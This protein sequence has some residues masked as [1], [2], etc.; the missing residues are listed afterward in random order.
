MTLL[1]NGF[2][3]NL[4]GKL[5]GGRA[6]DGANP[7]V[8]EYLGHRTAALRNL[9][10]GEG[11]RNPQASAPAGKRAPYAWIMAQSGGG[12]SSY[13]RTDIAVNAQ[14]I[15]EM[16]FPRGG[17]TT[18]TIDGVGVLGLV[19]GVSG[20]TTISINASAALLAVLSASGS[21]TI[22]VDG[23]GSL[24]ADAFIAGSTLVT[25]EGHCDLSALGYLTGTT[26][27]A[28]LTPAGIAKAVWDSLLADFNAT[29]TAG[30]ALASAGSGGVDLEALAQAILAAA[31]ITPIHAD[32]R[33][34]QGQTLKGDGSEE[35]PW[36]P[37]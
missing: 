34:V 4:T 6:L 7:S 27:E 26:I 11:I 15:A 36:N 14:M 3:H 17:S 37:A 8:H 21:T 33:K 22:T 24:E 28:G 12:L 35:N 25:I 18:I 10:A 20:S 31:Q 19:A 1:G 16:G 2:R 29:G 23:S 30:K 5:F 13:R 9:T 32:L